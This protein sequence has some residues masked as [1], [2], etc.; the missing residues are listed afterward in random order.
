[1]VVADWA[2]ML[3]RLRAAIAQ[4]EAAPPGVPA[5]LLRES[6]AFL[7]WLE[8][9]NFTF[10][11]MREYE[12][13]GN[14]ET[15]DLV[16]RGGAGLGVLR[17]EAVQVLRRGTELVAMTP[18]VR[19]FFFAPAPL[20]I[21]KAN[22]LARVHR[23]AH[24]DYVGIKT[25]KGD[26][27]PR[28]EIRVVGL[29]T[30]QAYVRSPV[31][32]PFLRHKVESVLAGSGHPPASHDGK[33]LLNILDTFPR[34][35]LFQISAGQLQEW[36]EGMLELETR[37]R[38]RVFA[39][40]D[41]FDRFVSV[42][43]YAPRDR[44]NTKVRERIGALLAEVYKGSVVAFYPHFGEGPLVRVQFIIA[45]FSGATPSPDTAEI[46]RQI[47]DIVR[48]WDD[49]LADAIAG[50]GERAEALQAKYGAAFSSGYAETF[51]AQRAL[52]DIERIERLGPD[53]PIAI[54]FYRAADAPPHR[55]HAAVY[56]FGAPISLS[57]RVPVLENLG[58]SAIDERSYR[59]TPRFADGTREVTLHDMVLE[60]ADGAP[61]DI[62]RHGKR[63]ED[64]FLS[65]FRGEADN[66]GF[67]RLVVAAERRLAR[68]RRAQGLCRLPAPARLPVRA[69]LPRRYADAPCRARAR[70]P[71]AVPS[72]LRPGPPPRHGRPRGCGGAGPGA[73]RERARHRAEPR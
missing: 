39:R 70:V 21:T 33:A 19:R 58:F 53:R 63:L 67:N 57:E 46:E 13:S 28:G 37:P 11:G 72:A 12:L 6:I 18:E 47:V 30:S 68:G 23:R 3:E 59:I 27:T 36:A 34:D 5:D 61:I 26:G 62:G 56:R 64:C 51:P 52:G 55:I 25:Y 65:V 29:F 24:M 4:L 49:R 2:P 22:V 40:I 71:G 48:T 9:G 7:Q 16:P 20:I 42:L 60:S 66:D 41:R 44:Y 14:A 17:D 32:I 31:E 8:A 45:R 15:G 10:L 38:V 73:H 69:A 54:D 1:M 50:L 43:V 35:E